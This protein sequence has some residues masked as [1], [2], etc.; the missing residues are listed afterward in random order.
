ML[1]ADGAILL[2][3]LEA[4]GAAHDADHARPLGLLRLAE[5]LDRLGDGVAVWAAS[6]R[7]APRPDE[8]IDDTV[9]R[10]AAGLAELGVPEEPTEPPRGARSRG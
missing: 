3:T 9:T 6:D 1:R 2:A 4:G 10:V 8:A 7:Q 5:D